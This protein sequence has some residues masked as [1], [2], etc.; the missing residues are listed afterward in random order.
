MN[1]NQ[2]NRAVAAQTDN[3][4]VKFQMEK[5]LYKAD[6]LEMLKPIEAEIL[7]L[8]SLFASDEHDAMSSVI[9]L[10]RNGHAGAVKQALTPIMELA[11]EIKKKDEVISEINEIVEANFTECILEDGTVEPIS[12]SE[13]AINQVEMIGGILTD[14]NC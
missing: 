13:C 8:G 7:K 2:L 14:N 9:T 4:Q 11:E 12:I 5:S 3:P 6:L 1:T 10:L